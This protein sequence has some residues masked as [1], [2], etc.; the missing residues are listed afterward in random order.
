MANLAGRQ[1]SWWLTEKG[2]RFSFLATGTVLSATLLAQ[3]L[4]HTILIEK[5]KEIICRY[6]K[7]FPVP[8]PDKLAKR[9]EKTLDLL[10]I[11]NI[12]RPLFKPFM[13]HGFDV[14]SAGTMGRFG[15][16]IGIPA[17]FEYSNEHEVDKS[18][19][20]V[21][22]TSV[23]WETEEGERLLHALVVPESGQIYALAREIK[24]R[25]S[26]KTMIDT[27]H[28]IAWMLFTYM[29][30]TTV[31][32]K[33]NLYSKPKAV[34]V[35]GYSLIGLFCGANYIMCKD[36]TQNLYEEKIDKELKQLDP[37]FAEGGKQFYTQ[38]LE[39]NKALRVLMG[40][41]GESTYT[42][43]GNENF[44]FRNKHSPLVQRKEFFEQ[45]SATNQEQAKI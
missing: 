19:I 1:V 18:K 22:N 7:G 28:L 17:N 42:V 34:R 9:F 32:Q 40:K 38:I 30:S 24:L 11:E 15:I 25:Y 35:I 33:F 37:I 5:Y 44:L 26:Y 27:F 45:E 23:I 2:K 29:G 14:I 16:H 41:E 4:P 36:I 31:N 20:R 43:L 13:A 39:R 6:N 21:N 8:V 10:K 3:T 12:Y